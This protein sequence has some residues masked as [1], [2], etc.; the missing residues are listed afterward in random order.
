MLDGCFSLRS[1]TCV[2][3]FLSDILHNG[4]LI[5]G[6][7]DPEILSVALSL[8]VRSLSELLSNLLS[9]P[10]LASPYLL[11]PPY[12][13]LDILPHASTPICVWKRNMLHADIQDTH[14]FKV[15]GSKF[16][17]MLPPYIF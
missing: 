9:R 13:E 8:I 4:W 6:Q 2:L 11:C 3:K 17:P 10:P 16:S 1:W 5:V 7:P 12:L 14:P 15:L